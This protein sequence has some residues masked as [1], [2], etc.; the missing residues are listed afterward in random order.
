M[1]KLTF[2]YKAAL[3]SAIS[4]TTLSL[5]SLTV[6]A[7]TITVEGSDIVV[8][9]QVNNAQ[10]S[11]PANHELKTDA[12]AIAMLAHN[13]NKGS[14]VVPIAVPK[15]GNAYFDQHKRLTRE[16][17]DHSLESGLVPRPKNEEPML[18]PDLQPQQS[19]RV[20]RIVQKSYPIDNELEIRQLR[21]KIAQLER[22][23]NENKPA[24]TGGRSINMSLQ[25]VNDIPKISISPGYIANIAF[26]DQ[27]GNPW[28][29]A[30]KTVGSMEYFNIVDLAKGSTNQ[31]QIQGLTEYGTTNLV[32]LL[33]TATAPLVF[34]IQGSNQND[35]RVDVV[36]S[37]VAPGGAA[38]QA[39]RVLPPDANTAYSKI[40]VNLRNGV[41]DHSLE[42]LATNGPLKAYRAPNG[43]LY[44]V[45]TSEVIQPQCQSI[46]HGNAGLKICQLNYTPSSLLYVDNGQVVT[47]T[48]EKL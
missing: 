46:V 15:D 34:D 5:G 28:N 25:A 30:G 12:Q 2:K 23:Q 39:A 35:S 1:R 27:Y 32:V 20:E 14:R 9:E 4:I 42:Q 37:G 22:A 21:Q 36:I 26:I 40:M 45:T 43:Y 19:A 38:P 41:I 16:E 24:D 13:T 48:I 6:Q 3:L 31:I 44:V 7:A 47:A 33:E 8:S 11:R 29:I 18:L 17:V 10:A